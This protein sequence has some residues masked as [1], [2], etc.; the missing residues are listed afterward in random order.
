MRLVL[1]GNVEQAKA[2][3]EPGDKYL[4][5]LPNDLLGHT[6]CSIKETGTFYFRPDYKPEEI[7]YYCKS[8]NISMSIW[9]ETR[10]TPDLA[11]KPKN[12]KVQRVLTDLVIGDYLDL[13]VDGD[14]PCSDGSTIST[15]SV[16]ALIAKVASIKDEEHAK[17][18]DEIFEN[19]KREGY[20]FGRADAE[21][22]A[23]ARIEALIELIGDLTDSDDC[24]LD[25]HGNCQNHGY[26]MPCPMPKAQ[27]VFKD[28]KATNKGL[29]D[30]EISNE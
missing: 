14:Y 1:A 13:E 11:T 23:A 22:D 3:Y 18:N 28:F 4:A 9:L 2:I 21:L 17:E 7:Y 24:S 6:D 25:H 19:G 10:I 16:D 30:K 29:N 27:K 5:C 26:S 20:S 8:H 12:G 15:I